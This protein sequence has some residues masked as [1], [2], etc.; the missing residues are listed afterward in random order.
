MSHL[1]PEEFLYLA[2]NQQGMEHE[3]SSRPLA[4]NNRANS[5]KT[6][7]LALRGA[8]STPGL[9]STQAGEEIKSWI[10]TGGCVLWLKGRE[11]TGR[12]T[13]SGLA[14][15]EVISKHPERFLG[16]IRIEGA[17]GIRFEEALFEINHFLQ[18]LGIGDLGTVLDQQTSLASKISVLL[19]VLRGHP[20]LLW[21]D[22]FDHFNVTGGLRRGLSMGV[23]AS[24][25]ADLSIGA[26]RLLLVT[27]GDGPDGL[28]SKQAGVQVL[29]LGKE[30]GIKPASQISKL[31][32]L[33]PLPS[34]MR[35]RIEENPEASPLEIKLRHAA[36]LSCGPAHG[37]EAEKLQGADIPKLTLEIRRRM[38]PSARQVLDVAAL[39]RAP[40]GRGTVRALAPPGEGRSEDDLAGELVRWGLA[41]HPEVENGWAIRIHPA[42]A[43]AVDRQIHEN[44]LPTWMILQ[45]KIAFHLIEAG[46]RTGNLWY[47][48]HSRERLFQ[49]GMIPE[50]YEVQKAFLEELLRRG[51]NE[52]AHKLLRESAEITQGA[53]RAVSLG[54]LAILHKNNGDLDEAA[55]LYEEVQNEFEKLDDQQN[56]ARVHHQLGNIHFLRGDLDSALDHY[57]KSL[58]TSWETG[59]RTVAAATRIQ[60]ANLQYLR[61]E[62]QKALES[63]RETLE[64]A[65][66]IQDLTFRS[67]IHL[68]VGQ[69]LLNMRRL[70]EAEGELHLAEEEAKKL[71]DHRNLIKAN[72]LLGLVAGE[73]RDYDQAVHHLEQAAHTA[74]TLGDPLEMAAC[75]LKIGILERERLQFTKAVQAM[76]CARDLLDAA[77]TRSQFPNAPDDLDT[78]RKAVKDQMKTVALHVGPEVFGRILLNLGR[79]DPFSEGPP[80]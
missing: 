69:L 27:E 17:P 20:I 76:F 13:L 45:K 63:Y 24:G 12:T 79:G 6:P 51:L 75:H 56:I 4:S 48:L 15:R 53:P 52:L 2:D 5:R 21:L 10:I 40:L 11:G 18:Q 9:L 1:V 7:I 19:E 67:A 78:Y 46:N 47:F 28:T 25:W 39:Y 57:Q 36:L 26:G 37:P 59:E 72:Q 50:G 66:N 74:R 35:R 42:V 70:S 55:R 43:R 41:D 80:N 29:I 8:G 34:H 31:C 44:D 38:E 65:K 71:G 77:T 14:I 64:L 16:A 30:N 73:R 61:G 58:Q 32:E 33:Q 23:F 68:Q 22:D 54:N 60:I 62:H 3:N 49:A